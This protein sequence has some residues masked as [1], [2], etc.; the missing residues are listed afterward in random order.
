MAI[1]PTPARRG[2]GAATRS[3]I[4]VARY[5]ATRLVAIL[6]TMVV[7]VYIVIL[8]A[9]MGGHVDVIRKAQIREG[10]GMFF[11]NN[12]DVQ[13]MPAEERVALMDQ[14]VA[15]EEERLGLNTPFMIRS[16]TYL[17]NA[18]TL[19][20]GRAEQLFSDSGS[21][22]VRLILL[23]RLPPTLYL[24][25]TGQ[26][27]LFFTAVFT[28][29]YLSQRYASTLDRI[30]VALAPTS[31]APAWFY[32]IFLILIF[33]AVLKV[34]PFGGMVATPPPAETWRYALSLLKHLVLPVT[35]IMMG[36]VFQAIYFWRTFFLIFSREDYVEMAKAKGLSSRTVERRYILR[37][38]LPAIVTAFAFMVIALWTGAIVLET[39][40]RWPGLGRLLW[41][42]IGLYDTPVIVGAQV[43]YA[44]LL[45]MT[46]FVLEI[47]YAILDPRVGVGGRSEQ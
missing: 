17:R 27:L 14:I 43:I 5:T 6:A 47:V 44:Y 1:G 32:G 26:I 24:M 30:L 29:L 19:N 11:L 38:T 41:Q 39:V 35:A 4:R 31:A 9:N 15:L 42:A 20:L 7:A 25:F 34:M 36:A 12:P 23:E 33:A 37:P 16:F 46:V 21:R 18:L 10:V 2:T 40:F 22:Q 3:L 28:A 13:M 8:I 45:A